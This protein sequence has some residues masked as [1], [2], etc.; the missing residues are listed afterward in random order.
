[1]FKIIDYKFGNIY[2][3]ANMLNELGFKS[4]IINSPDEIKDNDRIILP[5]VGSYDNAI[6]SLIKL[7]FYDL[8]KYQIF[9]K[10]LKLIGICLGM[11]LMCEGSI[12]GNK[13]GLGLIKGVCKKFSNRTFIGWSK[14]SINY[15]FINKKILKNFDD[16]ERYYFLHSYYLPVNDN[17]SF[18]NCSNNNMKFTAALNYKNIYGFQFHPER[19]HKFGMKVFKNLNT[20]LDDTI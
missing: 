6:I 2:S 11:Q 10:N 9:N 3:I 7:G 20:I 13:E 18:L 14:T 12:E 17:Y 5:G 8:L 19:S 15:N 1:M 16:E 4:C